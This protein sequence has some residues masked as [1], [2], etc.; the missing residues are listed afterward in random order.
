MY[1]Y[2]SVM[3]GSEST[4]LAVFLLDLMGK[5]VKTSEEYAHF[6]LNL[7]WI[8]LR[9]TIV[10]IAIWF[11]WTL[12]R[13][14]TIM[15]K[16]E[17]ILGSRLFKVAE[18]DLLNYFLYAMLLRVMPSI[19]QRLCPFLYVCCLWHVD[20]LRHISPDQLQYSS[21]RRLKLSLFQNVMSYS[22]SVNLSVCLSVYAFH[23][24]Q[25]LTCWLMQFLFNRNSCSLSPMTAVLRMNPGL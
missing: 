4:L 20:I 15:S 18:T 9:P 25:V 17:M 7:S 23:N 6:S 12:L 16:I 8:L 1:Q 2:F 10:I 24:R 3:I 14:I 11:K 13:L 22:L 19:C 21:A 5:L